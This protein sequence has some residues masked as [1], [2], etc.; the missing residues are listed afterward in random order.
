MA[1]DFLSLTVTEPVATA[2]CHFWL[3]MNKILGSI[4][5]GMVLRVK[6]GMT[7]LWEPGVQS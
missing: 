2:E 3:A 7:A 6:E 4:N 5:K 1:G